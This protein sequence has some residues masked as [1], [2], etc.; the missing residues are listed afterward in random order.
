MS[1]SSDVNTVTGPGLPQ[2]DDGEGRVDGVLV[3][4]Q[5]RLLEKAGRLLGDLL[6][7]RLDTG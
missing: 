1:S 4:V 6:G 7:H 3:A 5:A 2:G